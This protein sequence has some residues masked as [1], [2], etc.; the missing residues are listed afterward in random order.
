MSD[1]LSKIENSDEQPKAS[2]AKGSKLAVNEQAAAISLNNA[3]ESYNDGQKLAMD[4]AMSF[5]EG[6]CETSELVTEAVG[7]EI[8]KARRGFSRAIASG[9]Q[10]AQQTEDRDAFLTDFTARL[11]SRISS[12]K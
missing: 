2:K 4:S 7:Q 6:F 10:E 8:A 1:T 5:V 3:S 11:S 12:L 9:L